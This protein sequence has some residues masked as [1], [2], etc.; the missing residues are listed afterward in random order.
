MMMGHDAENCAADLRLHVGAG[1]GNR[2]RAI[3]LGI[4]QIRVPDGP[5]LGTRCTVSDRRR[6]YD[7]GANGPPMAHALIAR[8]RVVLTTGSLGYSARSAGGWSVSRAR[9]LW[10]LKA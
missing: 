2:T 9:M 3:S 6:P 10:G 7:T 4:R 8:R 1:D 5:D